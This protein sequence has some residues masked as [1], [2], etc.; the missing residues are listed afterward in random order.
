MAEQTPQTQETVTLPVK[1][2]FPPDVISRYATNIVVQHSEHEFTISF[3]EVQKPIILGTPAE[4][5]AQLEQTEFVPM[6][7]VAR[8]IV[9]ASKM[10][11]FVKALQANL[12]GHQSQRK[13]VE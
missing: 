2:Q 5:K 12:A 3:F 11:E 9:S 10:P 1:W 7:C 8:V 6:V 4:R 13:Q